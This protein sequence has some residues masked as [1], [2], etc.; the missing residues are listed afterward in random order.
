MIRSKNIALSNDN[1]R[2]IHSNW[3]G[4]LKMHPVKFSIIFKSNFLFPILIIF[5]NSSNHRNGI[6][7]RP[8]HTAISQLLNERIYQDRKKIENAFGLEGR[9][10][11]HKIFELW[12]STANKFRGREIE[13]KQTGFSVPFSFIWRWKF[14]IYILTGLMVVV[15]Q[16]WSV[17]GVSHAT[18]FILCI[19]SDILPTLT[20]CLRVF[21]L[22]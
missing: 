7:K 9:E 4:S 18:W 12:L 1:I 6:Q 8:I 19:L 21:R 14:W 5:W 16:M 15:P 3:I 22:C 10:K 11:G 20:W 13:T 17:K 2:G